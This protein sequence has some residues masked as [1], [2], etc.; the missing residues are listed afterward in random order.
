VTGPGGSSDDNR[1]PST[2]WVDRAVM[3]IVWI[4]VA[5]IVMAIA[6][7]LW[8]RHTT[9]AHPPVFGAEPAAGQALRIARSPC[10][11]EPMVASTADGS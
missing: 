5:V 6:L 2:T 7:F 11:S 4:T 9:Q 8:L 3:V 10:F 1:T